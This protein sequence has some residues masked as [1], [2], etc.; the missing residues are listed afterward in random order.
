MSA[1][2]EFHGNDT[3]LDETCDVLATVF[4]ERELIDVA[5]T[6][7]GY[8]M[9]SIALNSL[10]VQPEPGLSGFLET[11]PHSRPLHQGAVHTRAGRGR[12]R[13]LMHSESAARRCLEPLDG[14]APASGTPSRA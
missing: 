9:V 11:D 1:A 6:V 7:A 14:V 13:S 2:D 10:G 5:I 12:L 4:D 8:K 3:I